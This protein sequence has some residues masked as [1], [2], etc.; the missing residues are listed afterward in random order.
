M[1][2]VT[3][4]NMASMQWF[5]RCSFALR[6]IKD[7]E[8]QLMNCFNMVTTPEPPVTH[9]PSSKPT[10]RPSIRPTTSHKPKGN[11]HNPLLVEMKAFRNGRAHSSGFH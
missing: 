1:D 5:R 10:S 9:A 6:P 8:D 4:F 7:G 3:D 2:V 11:Q